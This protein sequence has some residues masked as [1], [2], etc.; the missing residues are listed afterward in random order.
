MPE[1]SPSC[2]LFTAACTSGI[3]QLCY[4]NLIVKV[5]GSSRVHFE[6]TMNLKKLDIKSKLKRKG[7]VP[8]EILSKLFLRSSQLR[9]GHNYHNHPMHKS[10]TGFTLIELL[11]VI[12]ILAVLMLT[13]V[14]TLNPVE[15]LRQSRDTNRLSDMAT[16]KTAISLYM[17]DVATSTNLGAVNTCYASVAA[18]P[19]T[20]AATG[21]FI[22]S[23]VAVLGSSTTRTVNGTGWIPINFNLI[24]A[25][26]P[27]SQLP[28]DPL[29]TTVHFYGF[30]ASGTS[31]FKLAMSTESTKFSTN[32]TADVESTDGG[33][34]NNYYETGPGVAAL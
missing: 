22:N 16:L 28:I 34:Y 31:I 8:L 5:R 14:V 24:S 4:N 6:Q 30:E 13:V 33:T 9:D 20:A 26:A 27:V 18:A 2:H 1:D 15:L 29:N 11:V 3:Y 12:A 7:F 17:A 23:V 32:G 19:C 25:G 10:L 21:G